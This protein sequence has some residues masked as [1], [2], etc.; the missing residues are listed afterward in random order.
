MAQHTAWCTIVHMSTVNEITGRKLRVAMVDCGMTQAQVAAKVGLSR[1]TVN[2]H[3]RG[4][5]PVTVEQLT[6]YAE[7]LGANFLVAPATGLEPVTYRSKD[8]AVA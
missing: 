5:T 3:M 4:A 6:R 8:R 7:A 2:K 1:E